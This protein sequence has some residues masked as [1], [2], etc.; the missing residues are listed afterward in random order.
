MKSNGFRRFFIVVSFAGVLSAPAMAQR[1]DSLTLDQAI[2]I[3]MKR[4]P[5]IRQ[6]E[7]ALAAAK[8]HTAGLES[9]NY[10]SVNAVAT[11]MYLGPEYPFAL[12]P[13][14]KL[15]M[16]PDNS[17]DAHIGAE[18]TLYDFGKRRASVETGKTGEISAADRLEGVKK[19][20]S[21]QVRQ[22]FT[23]II[24]QEKSLRV[25]DDG[26]AEL[27][28][29]LEVLKKKIETGSATEYD[30]LKT[31]VQRAG[32]RSTRIDIANDLDKKQSA[33]LQ[34]L[35][36][37]RGTPLALS[38]T[39]DTL[40]KKCTVDSLV[41]VALA[42]RTD[43][44]QALHAKQAAEVQ[45][46]S[47]KLENVPVLGLRGSAGFKN[48]LPNDK[49]PPDIYT[50]RVN[51]AAGAVLSMPLYDGKRAERREKESE[52]LCG[53]AAAAVSDREEHIKTDVMQAT[54]DV[55]SAYSRLDVSRAQIIFAQ[56]SLE[57]AR[58]KYDA[59]VITNLDVLD[60]EN[61]FSEAQLHHL[62]NQFLYILS[63]YQ[64]DRVTGK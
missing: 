9:A 23:A 34:L 37:A 51:W 19:D 27:D 44:A 42:C 2:H 52:R 31:E 60:A 12:A 38:G 5:S 63:L 28:R 46:K 17:F 20:L 22:F 57:L 33:L 18:Y 26:I 7:E 64:L 13:G 25:A 53:S 62:Q 59:G 47:V 55:G 43:Y 32:A 11:D 45:L 41:V 30:V 14:K 8:E 61:D 39:I 35:G 48:G 21:F 16:V 36:L 58:L 40:P 24:L 10:P 54:A 56:R 3:V 29:H 15:N 50:P 6:A 49:M 1:Q 4:N